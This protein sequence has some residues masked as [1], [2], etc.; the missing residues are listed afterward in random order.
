MGSFLGLPFFAGVALGYI[1]HP[2]LSQLL[3][4]IMNMF[5]GNYAESNFA[6]SSMPYNYNEP[7]FQGGAGLAPGIYGTRHYNPNVIPSFN[8]FMPDRYN[9]S[10]NAYDAQNVDPYSA[11]AAGAMA[12]GR[13]PAGQ[14]AVMPNVQIIAPTKRFDK[15]YQNYE[16]GNLQTL[17]PLW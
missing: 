11:Y 10:R 13:M 3:S 2:F 16:Q 7:N 15:D 9:A 6:S 17:P 5:K 4:P 12:D 14:S 1:G 8:Q